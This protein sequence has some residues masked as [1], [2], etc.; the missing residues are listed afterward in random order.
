MV[1]PPCHS[2]TILPNP[3]ILRLERIEREN[4]QFRL[5]VRV[6]QRAACPVCGK[7]SSSGHS[8]YRRLLQDLPWQ[9]VS[10]QLWVTAHRYRCR[11]KACPRKIFCERLPKVA[12][13]HARQTGR[14]SEIVHLIG[15]IAGG[16]PGQR[17]LAR[18][19][20]STSDDTVLRRLKEEADW[21]VPTEIR[22]LGVDD[23]AWRKG[24]EYGTILVN[25]DLHRVADLLPDRSTESLSEWLQQRRGIATIARDRCGL[26]AEGATLGAPNAQQVADRFHLILNLSTT[27]ERVLEERRRY[28]ILPPAKSA[29]VAQ[30]DNLTPPTNEQS[31][32][33]P[34]TLQQQRR[35]RR[36]QRYQQVIDL[37]AKGYSKK[38]ISREL[39][40]ETKTI[41]RWL[42]AG[43]F[44]ERKAPHRRPPKVHEFAEYLQQR[45]TEGCHNATKLYEEIREKG[46]R[47]KRSMVAR[48]VSGWRKTGNPTSPEAPQ[49]IAPKHAAILVTR[50]PDRMSTEQQQL[51][52]R[53]SNECPD[54]VPLRRI[55]LAFREALTSHEGEKM[56]QWIDRTKRC[57][58]GSLVRFAYGLQKDISAVTAAVDTPWS[59]GQVEW[60]INR[61]KMIKRQMYGRAGFELLRARVL[62][63]AQPSFSDRPSP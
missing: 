21:S 32:S 34:L 6:Q 16:L 17:L 5:F 13:A 42:R 63:F 24:Q 44:P 27:I 62:P 20:V 12:R 1:P 3:G 23:W 48:Y 11:N 39:G 30:S 40:I 54:V 56:Q 36:L 58:F 43:E 22:H 52:D 46:Y 55:S 50:P 35:E 10:V 19:A 15:Y 14:T 51:F 53:I 45:W 31:P 9:G 59:T 26:Y 61:L 7:I 47:G 57:E 18:L 2:Q 28:L 60:Q 25:L 8:S 49:R 4:K 37:Y 33:P 41:R 29:P 38:A